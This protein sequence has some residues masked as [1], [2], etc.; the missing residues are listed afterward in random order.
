[1]PYP[2][3]SFVRP[4]PGPYDKQDTFSPI[5]PYAAFKGGGASLT[6]KQDFETAE[7]VS[8][9]AYRRGNTNY[10]FDD[11]PTGTPIFYVGVGKGDQPNRSFTQEL[12][13]NSKGSGPIT[14]TFGLFYYH[15]SNANL[16][17]VRQ[18]FPP[19]YGAVT[20]PPTANRT[21]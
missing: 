19:F 2:G 15:N 6:I 11:V 18:F 14:Y 16:P 3:T 8:I 17:I 21:T 5:D 10:L 1:M 7:L 20:G 12:Q 9:T 13:L 4:L